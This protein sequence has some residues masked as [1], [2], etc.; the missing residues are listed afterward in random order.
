MPKTKTTPKPTKRADRPPRVA[1]AAPPPKA[2][3]ASAPTLTPAATRVL[4]FSQRSDPGEGWLV[5]QKLEAQLKSA[6]VQAMLLD[7]MS[8]SLDVMLKV[9][10]YG[11]TSSP[12]VVVLGRLAGADR[13]RARWRRLP[14]LAE[15]TVA[16]N[17]R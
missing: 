9:A 2:A 12:V 5:A 17:G 14:T 8:S 15:V 11:V 6:N 13:V 3:P 7:R 4:I 16:I 1:R 10:H